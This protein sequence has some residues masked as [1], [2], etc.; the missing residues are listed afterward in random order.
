MSFDTVLIVGCGLIGSSLARAAKSLG[1]AKAVLVSDRDADVCET[2]TRLGFADAVDTDAA[3][4]AG[5][6]DLV[7]LCVPPG[8]MGAAGA[9][10]IPAMKKGAVLTDVGSVKGS[11]IDALTP[12]ITP[13]VHLVPGHPIAGTEN[14]GPEAGFASLFKDRWCILTPQDAAAPGVSD[15]QNFWEALGSRVAIMTPKRHDLV[16]AATSHVPHL[17][18]FTLVGTATDM[19][20]VTNNEVIKYSAGGFR[21]FT[22]IAAS[23]PTMWRDVFLNN[24]DAVLEVVDRF[25]ED[26]SALKKAIRWGEGEQLFDQFSKTREIR[27]R[28][29]DAGQDTDKP[30]FGRGSGEEE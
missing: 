28:I 29:V 23:D 21:D 1:V 15:L 14:S 8:A 18:A 5:D 6:A 26:L 19:E 16:L 24:S 3:K 13:D 9:A 30:N 20:D 4:L 7:V 27:R 25:I 22:R 2:V 12:H 11:V 17:L 10:I